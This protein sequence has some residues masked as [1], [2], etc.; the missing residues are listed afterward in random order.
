VFGLLFLAS[1][2]WWAVAYYHRLDG[3]L[4]RPQL[5]LVRGRRPD[6]ARCPRRGR[7]PAPWTGPSRVLA[8]V[9]HSPS[10]R[11]GTGPSRP[12]RRGSGA[13]LGSRI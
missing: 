2:G 1:A 5:R 11:A 6:P 12:L 9:R 3:Q 7:E 8:E 4:E 10:Q 13:D